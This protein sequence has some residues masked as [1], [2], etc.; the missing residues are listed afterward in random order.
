MVR[1]A[2][3]AGGEER[4]TEGGAGAAVPAKDGREES[5]RVVNACVHGRRSRLWQERPT[6]A[7]G[8]GYGR[9]DQLW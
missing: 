2:Q 3:R 6:M 7:D 5:G 8:A 9:N 4:L 1:G